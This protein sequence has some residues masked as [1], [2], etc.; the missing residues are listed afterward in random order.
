MKH[1]TLYRYLM[2]EH[3]TQ[4]VLVTQGF[5]CDALERPWK[6]NEVNVSCIPIGEYVVARDNWGKHQYYKV[7]NVPDRTHIELHPA[8]EVEEL[9]G[10]IALGINMG[11][12]GLSYSKATLLK[13]MQFMGNEQEFKLTIKE[14]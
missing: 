14:I 10:C 5:A 2:N 1:F 3:Q 12:G 4:G 7:M 9:A 6:D 11:N 8:N 13:L